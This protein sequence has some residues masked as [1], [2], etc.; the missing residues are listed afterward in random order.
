MYNCEPMQIVDVNE[1]A[2]VQQGADAYE[3]RAKELRAT[4]GSGSAVGSGIL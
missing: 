2:Q 4:K 1:I 3:A